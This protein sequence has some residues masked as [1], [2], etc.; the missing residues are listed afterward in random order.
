MKVIFLE[1]SFVDLFLQR[2]SKYIVFAANLFVLIQ[3]ALE[4]T[5]EAVFSEL[6]FCVTFFDVILE[7]AFINHLRSTDLQN[8]MVSMLL[9][10]HEFSR[11]LVAISVGI[12]ASCAIFLTLFDDTLVG[13][14]VTIFY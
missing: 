14:S 13:I 1:V 5:I 12:D 10:I 9:V 8:T 2:E 7:S 3:V 4:L 6:D 11:V